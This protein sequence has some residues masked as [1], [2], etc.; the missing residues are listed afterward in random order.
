MGVPRDGC[1]QCCR[2]KLADGA[3]GAL[4]ETAVV[5]ALL[6]QESCRSAYETRSIKVP[7]CVTLSP[8]AART[9]SWMPESCAYRRLAEGGPSALA[10]PDAGDPES[11]HEA[12]A[13]V[14]GRVLSEDAVHRTI[15][16][17]ISFGGSRPDG[18]SYGMGGLRRRRASVYCLGFRV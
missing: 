5:C 18:E 14:R 8:E 12:G 15:S 10:S 17:P 3:A 6:D 16:R 11:V 4:A 9:L 7:D 2:I 1:A 13:S